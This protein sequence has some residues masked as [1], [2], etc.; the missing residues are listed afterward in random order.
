MRAAGYHV[1]TKL[2][3]AFES[4]KLVHEKQVWTHLI[5][6]L[7]V[8]I[9]KGNQNRGGRISGLNTQVNWTIIT[10]YLL[11]YFSIYPPALMFFTTPVLHSGRQCAMLSWPNLSSTWEPSLSSRDWWWETK[12]SSGE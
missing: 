6:L 3:S 9:I 4:A 1:L 11:G 5:S 7:R 10:L 2:N 12:Q 8:G